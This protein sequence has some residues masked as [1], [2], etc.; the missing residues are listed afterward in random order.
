MAFHFFT[1]PSK[2]QNQTSGQ[3]F[4]AIDENNYKLGNMFKASSNAK[5]FAITSGAVLVQ[6][7]EG[8]TA[9]VNI[10]L[11]PEDQPNLNFPKI[12]YIIY[13]GIVK[14]SLIDSDTVAARTKNDLTNTIWDSHDLLV[15]NQPTYTDPSPLAASALGFGYSAAA[16]DAFKA[17]D[18][19]SLN[20]AFYNN[21]NKLSRIESGDYLG[22]FN[23]DSLGI[24]IIF[25]KIGF[26]PTF[27]LA[28]QLESKLEFTALDP[29]ATLAEKFRRKH[30]K[31]DVLAFLD[32]A[33][34][35]SAFDGVDIKTFVERVD[36]ETVFEEKLPEDFYLEVTQKHIN[37]NAL[38]LDIRN[39][40]LDSF[41]YYENYSNTFNMDLLG[42]NS[43]V[44]KDYYGNEWPL[45]KLLDSEFDVLNTEKKLGL[46]L[47]KGDN[48]FPRIFLKKGNLLGVTETELQNSSTRFLD[49]ETNAEDTHYVMTH[50]LQIPKTDTGTIK[51]NYFQLNYIKRYATPDSSYQGLSLK[52]E[53]YLDN[54]F[55]IFDMKLPFV[56]E[57]K[58]N[59]KLFT[60]ACYIDKSN[61]NETEFTTNL[62]I[63]TDPQ[64]ISFIALP[65][66]YNAPD[67]NAKDKA[68]LYTEQSEGGTFV[69][70]FNNKTINDKI[71]NDLFQTKDENYKFLSFPNSSLDEVVL[72][73]PETATLNNDIAL[74]TTL[75][76][77]DTENINI[78][79]LTRDEYAQLETL[80][81]TEFSAPYKVYLGIADS[82]P[83]TTDANAVST[84]L[85]ALRGLRDNGSGGLEAHE[86]VT[87]IKVF[88]EDDL[89]NYDADTET[90]KVL[91]AY[92]VDEN[93]MIATKLNSDIRNNFARI[94]IKTEN[95]IGKPFEFRLHKRELLIDIVQSDSFVDIIT[96]NE[97]V[98]VFE[99]I[100]MKD[101]FRD[102][103]GKDIIENFY[104][105]IK[106]GNGKFRKY[107][108]ES[109]K[110]LVVHSVRYVPLA[111]KNR[112]FISSE[113][114]QL[115]WFSGSSNNSPND[116]IPKL[117][118]FSLDSVLT[119]QRMNNKYQDII[120]NE[121]DTE[122]SLNLL[123][124][125]ISLMVSDGNLTLPDENN[126]EYLF[127]NV[128]TEMITYN[129]DI[130]PTFDKYAHDSFADG[131]GWDQFTDNLDDVFGLL[132]KFVWKIYAYGKLTYENGEVFINIESI[133]IYI[134][135]S[136]DFNDSVAISQPL[137]FW[138]FKNNA[139]Y[140]LPHLN[141][142]IFP[143]IY[144]TNS[145]YRGWRNFHNKGGDFNFYSIIKTVPRPLKT[146]LIP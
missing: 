86:H 75:L 52:N 9:Q 87:D 122:N 134:K 80:K 1:E 38:Y 140:R 124:E 5:A 64:N 96:A 32:S 17:L 28:R 115:D 63:A 40:N 145:D 37:K 68:P 76:P 107:S 82:T 105:S 135:D 31:E 23:K 61:I 3:A 84:T 120:N 119:Y 67:I 2:L 85:Y 103:V 27:K 47:N 41:N 79:A 88:A 51:A 24:Q 44:E 132:G 33:A 35:F 83:L 102:I 48:E 114:V 106:I 139:F 94:L 73:N 92:W 138:D 22:D 30:D 110:N 19:D 25:E 100:P 143:R 8:N 95:A 142:L 117:D 53:S 108:Q 16:L 123:R 10:V 74:E 12:D 36:N 133:N 60:D 18:E 26:E 127:G 121:W 129:G 56:Q 90:A 11:K 104:F 66:Q 50:K 146:P 131:T 69:E 89:Y 112:E 113:K 14:T 101:S 118:Y 20:V 137:G 65:N 111:F 128:S 55:P 93:N 136:F 45:F 125:K 130:R 97:Q 81:N 98:F 58:V 116:V 21:E 126:T 46:A 42:D 43:F 15:A 7:I 4:G 54:L 34:F 70:H 57:K 71:R 141:P 29:A 91:Q 6:P 39:E 109:N 144:I 49:V 59:S 77:L 62:G 99:L 13:K 78:L 72:Q